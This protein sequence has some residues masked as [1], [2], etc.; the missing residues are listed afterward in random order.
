MP[1]IKQGQVGPWLGDAAANQEVPQA[2]LIHGENYL[3]RQVFQHI[4]NA[5]IPE[6]EIAAEVDLLE[7]ERL[8]I[9]E[10]IARLTTLSMMTDTLVVAA[11]DVPLFSSTAA[12]GFSKEDQEKLKSLLEK[13]FPEGHHLLIASPGADR[14]RALFK[15]FK[16]HGLVVDCTVP[17]GSRK[18]DRDAQAALLRSTMEAVLAPLGKGI[19]GR[20]FGRLT[21]LVGFDPPTLVDNLQKLA[22]YIGKRPGITLE[23]VDAVITR[24]RK[25]AVF[26]FTNA[27]VDRQPAPA[28]AGC[29]RMI[30]DGAHPLQL[31]KALVNQFRKLLRVK[32][33]VDAGRQAGKPVWHP[34]MPYNRF[35]REAVPA[36]TA[37]DQDSPPEL[38]MAPNPKSA[39]PVY[40]TFLKSDRFSLAELVDILTALADLDARLKTGTDHPVI[41]LEQVILRI[42]KKRTEPLGAVIPKVKTD[43]SRW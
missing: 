32:A 28:L 21:D 3:T 22:A 29:S 36:I 24:T 31:L 19:D 27:V 5:L 37:A 11:L 30:R 34:G 2:F 42:C 6:K 40:Q 15:A 17:T 4:R 13:G 33:F 38:A 1:E 10:M 20:A 16:K 39:Y 41:R 8:S 23:D 14:R 26:E 43:V 18:A 35:T 25:D 7:G 12:P 9:P